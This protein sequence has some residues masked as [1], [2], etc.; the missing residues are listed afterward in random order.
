MEEA[1]KEIDRLYR[2]L[3][4]LRGSSGMS[5]KAAAATRSSLLRRIATEV[6]SL[7]KEQPDRSSDSEQYLSVDREIRGRIL[8]EIQIILDEYTLAAR[9]NEMAKWE[10]MYGD[11]QYYQRNFFYF[12][13][14]SRDK[15]GYRGLSDYHFVNN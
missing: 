8:M 2:E 10:A 11:I 6:E 14:S 4:T 1:M 5:K 9:S 15:K 13:F 3:V 12:R 7:I